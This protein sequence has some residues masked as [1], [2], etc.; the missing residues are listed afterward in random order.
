MTPAQQFARSWKYIARPIIIVPFEGNFVVMAVHSSF[1]DEIDTFSPAELARWLENDFAR[2][3]SLQ[4]ATRAKEIARN[5]LLPPDLD[6]DF[7]L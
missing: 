6:I 5:F 2:Q 1:R 7:N 3:Q 4:E